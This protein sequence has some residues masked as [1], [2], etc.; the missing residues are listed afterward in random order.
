MALLPRSDTHVIS[1]E[2]QVFDVMWP[3]NYLYTRTPD[4]FFEVQATQKRWHQV[5]VGAWRFPCA[6]REGAQLVVRRPH[7][8]CNRITVLSDVAVRC[9]KDVFELRIFD[10]PPSSK[11]ARMELRFNGKAQSF[12]EGETRRYRD[13]PLG[14]ERSGHAGVFEVHIHQYNTASAFEWSARCNRAGA[15]DAPGTVEVRAHSSR[16]KVGTTRGCAPDTHEGSF[17][18]LYHWNAFAAYTNLMIEVDPEVYKVC[19]WECGACAAL[20][21]ETRSHQ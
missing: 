20:D 13:Y 12:V 3:G 14:K 15:L 2:N 19:A 1:F 21:A 7:Q 9:G 5:R 18:H 6:V 17:S 11:D 8:N 4:G 10:G 16:S